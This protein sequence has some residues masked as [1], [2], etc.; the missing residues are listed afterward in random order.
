MFSSSVLHASEECRSLY[1]FGAVF[2]CFY[3]ITDQFTSHILANKTER[4][5]RMEGCPY[6][7]C[8]VQL[9]NVQL[10]IVLL[11]NVQLPNI[12]LQDEDKTLDELSDM[13]NGLLLMCR[14][15]LAVFSLHIISA[16]VSKNLPCSGFLLH[17]D[18]NALCVRYFP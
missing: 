14:P 10:K 1:A 13:C 18:N 5:S 4:R 2:I 8:C 6:F 11:K 7:K 9:Q 16:E 17:R 3:C 15:V 12:L